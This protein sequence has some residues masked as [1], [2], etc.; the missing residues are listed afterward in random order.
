MLINE[1]ARRLI[2]YLAACYMVVSAG[3]FV[4]YYISSSVYFDKVQK[5]SIC[6]STKTNEERTLKAIANEFRS[7]QIQ[8]DYQQTQ[9]KNNYEEMAKQ[10]LELVSTYLV[11][12][13]EMI[14]EQLEAEQ[15]L[16]DDGPGAAIRKIDGEKLDNKIDKLRID[17]NTSPLNAK[18]S[19]IYDRQLE[20]SAEGNVVIRRKNIGKFTAVL[21]L[22]YKEVAQKSLTLG[23]GKHQIVWEMVAYIRM[24]K[25]LEAEDDQRFLE[26]LNKKFSLVTSRLAVYRYGNPPQEVFKGPQNNVDIETL[27]YHR[28]LGKDNQPTWMSQKETEDEISEDGEQ[29]LQITLRSLWFDSEV[30]SAFALDKI[31]KEHDWKF[32]YYDRNWL[33]L[34]SFAVLAWIVFPLGVFIAYRLAVRMRFK[35]TLD[36]DEESQSGSAVFMAQE[37]PVQAG[38]QQFIDHSESAED[39]PVVSVVDPSLKASEVTTPNF[40]APLRPGSSSSSPPPSAFS[41]LHPSKGVNLPIFDDIRPKELKDIRSNNIRKSQGTFNRSTEDRD[42]NMDYLQGVQSDVL[43]SLIKKLRGE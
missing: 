23:R 5:Q 28:E 11:S 34:W 12:L 36:L 3:L 1:K 40:V 35:M 15:L 16:E 17:D 22:D 33:V 42:H 32:S 4:V 2:V 6:N 43:K 7:L 38:V 39:A 29:W 37:Y 20:A 25:T 21:P 10:K 9:E 14:V 19:E 26:V 24:P 31:I 30:E 13:A 8:R 18:L 41:D 27:E